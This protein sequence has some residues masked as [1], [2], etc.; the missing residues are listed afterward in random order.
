MVE[1]DHSTL[2]QPEPE[3]AVPILASHLLQLEQKQRTRF[4]R[5]GRPEQLS[6]DCEDVDDI[7]GGGIERGIVMGISSESIEGRLVSHT[8]V[9]S[10]QS[11]L[12]SQAVVSPYA[13]FE[14]AP[15]LIYSTKKSHLS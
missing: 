2:L 4:I 5:D 7:L 15:S 10:L 8:K 13:I 9:V 14:A 6:T 11:S 1:L 12:Q 3:P